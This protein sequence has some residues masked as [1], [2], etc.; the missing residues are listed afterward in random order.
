MRRYFIYKYTFPNNKVYIGQTFVGCTRYG[1]ISQYK[2][3]VVYHAMKKYHDYKKEIIC[4][5]CEYLVDYLESY[6]ISKYDSMNPENGYN[7]ESGGH[8]NKSLSED[9]KKKISD[10]NK[11]DKC[12]WYGK[13]LSEETKRKISK[14]IICEELNREFYGA[15]EAAR[16]LGLCRQSINKCCQGK[17]STCGGYH[18]RYKEGDQ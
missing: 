9:A 2:R 18:F 12:Y 6:Y 10:S 8:E 1:H 15:A 5:C 3:Q 14:P 16:Q 13:N 7:R 11:G 17:R 4:Y